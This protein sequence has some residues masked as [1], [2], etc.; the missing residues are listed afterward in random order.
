MALLMLM[1]GNEAAQD[2]YKTMVNEKAKY[3]GLEKMIE[4]L[5]SKISLAQSQMKYIDKG[6][7]YGG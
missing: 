6:E 5:Q 7:K 3:R 2:L 1:E 4:S